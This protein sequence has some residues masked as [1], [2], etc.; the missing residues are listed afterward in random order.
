[1]SLKDSLKKVLDIFI[2]YIG[3][4]LIIAGGLAVIG[5]LIPFSMATIDVIFSKIDITFNPLFSKIVAIAYQDIPLLGSTLYTSLFS[6]IV[7]GSFS[8][9]SIIIL[10]LG[11][12]IA[13]F[14]LLE[15]LKDKV[16]FLGFLKNK[17]IIIPI[18]YL[19]LGGAAIIFALIE[20]FIF[21]GRLVDGVEN[22]YL[23][24]QVFLLNYNSLSF[25]LLTTKTLPSFG[26]YLISIPALVVVLISILLLVISI[27]GAAPLPKRTTT[28]KTTT[29]GT[30]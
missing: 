22:L 30:P 11:A 16:E 29:T 15:L 3:I 25:F 19:I 2:E 1:M 14:G 12:V 4:F 9:L 26:F 28:P 6:G 17:S 5:T 8:V 18:I 20:Y 13:I 24:F 27:Q 21:R 10:I 7:P 23:I